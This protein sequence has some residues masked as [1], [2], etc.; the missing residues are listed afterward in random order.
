MNAPGCGGVHGTPYRPATPTETGPLA[1]I[2]PALG[3][4]RRP[5]R[6]SVIT[7]SGCP[8]ASSCGCV[9]RDGPRTNI[10][11]R[12]SPP[13]A[14]P[15]VPRTAGRPDRGR[16][17]TRSGTP[18][19][20]NPRRPASRPARSASQRAETRKTEG[21]ACSMCRRGHAEVGQ[22][23]PLEGS[24]PGS[25]P[26]GPP[27]TARTWR[28]G[29]SG[30]RAPRNAR[31][32]S[33]ASTGAR[34][35]CRRPSC[36]CPRRRSR[37]T[38]SAM[39]RPVRLKSSTKSSSVAG[40]GVVD[41]RHQVGDVQA[42]GR[43]AARDPRQRRFQVKGV[44]A[45]QRPAEVEVVRR[46]PTDPRCTTGLRNSSPRLAQPPPGGP[47]AAARARRTGRARPWPGC[48]PRARSFAAMPAA[49]P[50]SRSVEMVTSTVAVKTKSCSLPMWAMCFQTF[51]AQSL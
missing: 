50:Q 12:G 31:A 7:H 4:R 13:A 2:G 47:A 26:P 9:P 5:S 19:P 16:D 39:P 37:P 25:P 10:G 30:G 35:A 40:R 44:E 8:L 23:H 22:A 42:D 46:R 21:P 29:G 51:G 49:M 17:R 28:G 20:A 48:R 38:I 11:R 24:R 34:P 43:G 6:S 32:R 41:Q 14:A 18:P 27:P 1:L 33:S 45:D 3:R 15:R 36:E